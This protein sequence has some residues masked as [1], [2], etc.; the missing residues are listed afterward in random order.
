M[1]IKR[2]NPFLVRGCETPR[3]PGTKVSGMVTESATSHQLQVDK[4]ILYITEKQKNN[5]TTYNQRLKQALKQ[6]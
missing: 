3:G 6:T 4:L 5:T 2:H 1:N